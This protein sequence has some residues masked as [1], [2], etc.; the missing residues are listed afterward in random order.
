M[1]RLFNRLVV[2][3]M[4]ALLFFVMSY[5]DG[6]EDLRDGKTYWTVQIGNQA[7]MD[8]NLKVQ[9]EGSWCYED[10]ESNCQKYG[11]LYDWDA[12]KSA[13]PVGWHLP[14]KEEFEA[15]FVAVGGKDIA[16]K[17]LKFT[18]G[19]N[20]DGNGEDA[21]A[22]S[23]LPAGLLF[24][25]DYDSEGRAAHFWSSTS[26][27]GSRYAYIMNLYYFAANA[28]LS[29]AKKKDGHSVRCLKD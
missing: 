5:D 20:S 9:T 27:P 29:Y 24:N 6:F 25:G 15:L 21:F 19:W 28:F 1:E 4:V 7:W 3:G 23:A 14:S 10:K 16:G 12:A 26:E 2:I 22:F 11:R 18:S 17:K 8:E 13:C